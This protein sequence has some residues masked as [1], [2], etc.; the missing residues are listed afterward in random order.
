MAFVPS[1]NFTIFF[2]SLGRSV[3]GRTDG[4]SEE[5]FEIYGR[6]PEMFVICFA[7]LSTGICHR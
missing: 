3:D 4:M 5:G 1:R 6:A 2:S 7:C